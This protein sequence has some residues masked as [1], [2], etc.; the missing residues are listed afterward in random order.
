VE[1]GVFLKLWKA[2]VEQFD[3]LYGIAWDWLAM[4]GALTKA[5]LGGEKN[6]T[7]SY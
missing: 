5:P 4:D 6:R 7:Q 3:E 1:A 2:G